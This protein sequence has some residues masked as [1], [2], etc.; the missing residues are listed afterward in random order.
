MSL[1]TCR[2][3]LRRPYH[4]NARDLRE[5]GHGPAGAGIDLDDLDFSSSIT[6]WMFMKSPDFQALAS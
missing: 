4:R 5:I 2:D 3:Y 6:N 1:R